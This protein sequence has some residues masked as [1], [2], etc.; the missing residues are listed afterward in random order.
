MHKLGIAKLNHILR[1][2]NRVA[3]A[4]AHFGKTSTSSISPDVV[5]FYNP[6]HFITQHLDF[7]VIGTASL[8]SVP[9]NVPC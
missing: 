8:Q 7:D 1:E 4:L 5:V 2:G 3:D 6:P 9:L